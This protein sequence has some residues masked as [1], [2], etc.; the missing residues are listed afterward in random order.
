M[1]TLTIKAHSR[2]WIKLWNPLLVVKKFLTPRLKTF[3]YFLK[4]EFFLHFRKW[5]FLAQRL[6]N[7]R[8]ELSGL[9]K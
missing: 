4:K 6:K 3:L 5:N 1:N 7:F 9:E 2:N 8:S